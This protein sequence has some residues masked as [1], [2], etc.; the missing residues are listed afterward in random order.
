MPCDPGGDRRR[1]DDRAVTA[2]LA[3]R[4]VVDPDPDGNRRVGHQHAGDEPQHGRAACRHVDR[5]VEVREKTRA[6]CT[7][8]GEADPGLRLA[9]PHDCPSNDLD[10]RVSNYEVDKATVVRAAHDAQQAGDN[11]AAPG[12]GWRPETGS[13]EAP[14]PWTPSDVKAK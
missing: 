1:G 5:H 4:P 10:R 14:E 13:E 3:D 7:A 9:K 12:R 2:A 8:A 6:A 11:L